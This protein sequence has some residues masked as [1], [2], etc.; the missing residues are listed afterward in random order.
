MVVVAHQ[1]GRCSDIVGAYC[2]VA[3]RIWMIFSVETHG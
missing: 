1:I 3:R 2:T